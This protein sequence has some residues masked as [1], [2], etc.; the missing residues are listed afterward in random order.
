MT[1]L[2]INLPDQ[3]VKEAKDA[4]LLDAEAIEAML[5]EQLRRRGT[6]EL[7]EAWLP[8]ERGAEA[9][10]DVLFGDYNPGGKLAMSFPRSVG[11][12]PVF[13]NHKPS[14]GRS[15]WR[16]HY[17]E[18]NAKPL[19]PF[20]FGMSYT[21]FAFSNLQLDSQNVQAGEQVR[22]H[23]DVT[24]TGQRAGDEV[25]Q[26]YIRQSGTSVTRPVKELKGFKRITLQAG[27][28][29]TLTF[30]LGVNQLA[31]YDTNMRFVIEPG[32]IDVMVGN[33]SDSIHATGQFEIGGPCTEV[34]DNKAYFS[35]VEIS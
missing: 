23:I 4:G 28:S 26:S 31:F 7:F 30:T 10:V 21:E 29:K 34:S 2:T 1:T 9:I 12:I 32:M 8:G 15:H 14:G 17:V 22:I 33:A 6:D 11:Q 27:E 35:G 13:Y 16:E 3:L 24:N 19:F 25:V 20:G 18:T 5:R